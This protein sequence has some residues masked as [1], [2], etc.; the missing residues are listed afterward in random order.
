MKNTSP[1]DNLLVKLSSFFFTYWRSTLIVWLALCLGAF[2]VYSQIIPREGFPPIEFPIGII[3]GTYFVDDVEKVD[4]NITAPLSSIL[5]D[6]EIVKET[7]ATSSEN[8]FNVIVIFEDEVDA[9]QGTRQLEELVKQTISLP[10]DLEITYTVVDPVSFLNEFEMLLSVYNR[11]G[12]PIETLQEVAQSVAEQLNSDQEVDNVKPQFLLKT[13]F[14]PESNQTETRQVSF[15]DIGVTE[16]G[17]LNFYPALSIGLRRAETSEMDIVEF[18]EHVQKLIS[19]L[20]LEQFEGEFQTEITGDFADAI[21]S[22][23]NA[24]EVNLASGLLAVMIVSL[25]L[26]S[27]RASII[28]ALFMISV[29]LISVLIL[30]FLGLTLNVIT[31]FAL[32]LSLGLFVDDA[33]I[34]VEVIESHRHRIKSS[35]AVIKESI[36]RVGMASLTGTLTT[37]LVFVPLLFITGI[38]GEFI[39]IMP[40]TIIVAL[41]S[42]LLL[43]L[44]LIPLLSRFLLLKNRK[45]SWLTR[46]NP[47]TKLETKTAK[48]L[49][50]KVRLMKN[51][52]SWRNNYWAILMICLSLV[53]IG[54]SLGFAR[55]VNFDIFPS[56]KDSDEMFISIDFPNDY[57]LSQAEAAIDTVNRSITANIGSNTE[58]V[59]YINNNERRAE[60]FVEL[61]SHTRRQE[62]S[63]QLAAEL[64]AALDKTLDPDIETKI[65]QQGPGGPAGD[66]PFQM[67]IFEADHQ[68]ALALAADI[69]QYLNQAT[70]ERP[71]GSTFQ[72]TQTRPPNSDT[73]IRNDGRLVYILSADFD[74]DDTS[75]ILQ[76]TEAYVKQRFDEAY[77]TNA[78]YR[79]D[80]LGFDFGQETD[81]ADSFNSLGIVF[82]ITI[83]AMFVVLALQFR[84][85][86]Q[87]LLIL[88][89]IPFTF[90]G[91]F[92]GLYY[93]NNSLSFF[94]QL[95][96]I[97]L[98][99]IAVNNTILLTDYANQERKRGHNLIEAVAIATEERFRP[100]VTTSLTTIVALLPLALSNPF[101]EALSYTIIFGLLSSTLLVVLAFPYYYLMVEWLRSKTFKSEEEQRPA[102]R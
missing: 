65:S 52:R 46:I 54:S 87:P 4:K 1:Q 97:G 25:L 81:N 82:P 37:V 99:G 72:V 29:M 6:A 80:T 10:S 79:A 83:I 23:I 39:R 56:S 43:S 62:K 92:A 42:S 58:Q 26:I 59:L 93:T 38:L 51:K 3:S 66:F 48:F 5:N 96:L 32:I 77:L 12:A 35:K 40:I 36:R 8:F 24:L 30:H 15:N 13:A 21:N 69:N 63:P 95:G 70:I 67:Q 91:V 11:Q 73:R 20:N 74:A 100:L 60:A 78:G 86:L 41:L 64:Q 55:H 88:L 49:A 19:E 9:E 18:S 89:A 50:D 47:I 94:S 17:E 102:L 44:I 27:W 71:N 98:I 7:Q 101:W 75:A 57:S 53:M 2:G 31:L 28:T 90:L 22:Q 16:E 68:R 45:V 85:W 33:T 34:I 76:A 14:N 61:I 84:S